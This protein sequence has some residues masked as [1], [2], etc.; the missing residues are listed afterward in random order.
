MIEKLDISKIDEKV[1][2]LVDNIKDTSQKQ[3]IIDIIQSRMNQ[4]SN[5]EYRKQLDEK[6]LEV[7]KNA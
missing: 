6:I 4:S 2:E 3:K 5:I 1:L 7:L